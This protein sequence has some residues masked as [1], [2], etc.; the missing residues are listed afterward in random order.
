[1]DPK[2]ELMVTVVLT[3]SD[4][5][6]ARAACQR[7]LDRVGG[8]VTHAADLLDEEPGCWT[9][10]TTLL[11]TAPPAGDGSQAEVMT[12]AARL[13]LTEIDPALNGELTC[14][15]PT[16][17]AVIDNAEAVG[18]VVDGGERL[19]LE[20]WFGTASLA[21]ATPPRPRSAT[22]ERLVVSPRDLPAEDTP[23]DG[24][25]V[26]DDEAVVLV[27][28]D[29]AD[30]DV[31]DDDPLD[32]VEEEHPDR[33]LLWVAVAPDPLGG[34]RWQATALSN[35]ITRY[36]AVVEVIE[37]DDM[38]CV[39]LDLGLLDRSPSAAVMAAVAA[40]GCPGWTP[41]SCVD[42]MV[43][44]R[45]TADPPPNVGVL[46]L[47]FTAGPLPARLAGGERRSDFE[48]VQP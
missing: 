7:L 5:R 12:A 42:G 20:V 10:T 29:T 2:L 38:T 16:A 32:D 13:L 19:M 44:T 30:E 18:A 8:I 6:Q 22:S 3:A 41:V 23:T 14:E 33:L 17:W 15:P 25:D 45:W 27:G 40:L 1:M 34:A 37:L 11:R 24:E 28:E 31:P 47:E 48:L 39:G 9:V 26:A 46:A 35:R 36:A 4:E 43:T 21:P